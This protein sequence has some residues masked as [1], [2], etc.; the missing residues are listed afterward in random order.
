MNKLYTI[1]RVVLGL[2]IIASGGMLVVSGG[3][4]IE[5]AAGPANDFNTALENTGYMMRI[6]GLVQFFSGISFVVNRYVPL[7]AVVFFPVSLSMFLF[8][9]FLDIPG[10]I[11]ALFIFAVN[12]FMLFKNIDFYRPMLK[13]K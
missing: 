8:H 6:V 7:M 3:A 5:F 9:L 10:I 12:I 4:P 2:F 11:P 13:S 1:L